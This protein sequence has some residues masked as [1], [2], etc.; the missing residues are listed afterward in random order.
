MAAWTAASIGITRIITAADLWPC[1][2]LDPDDSSS[3]TAA[4]D[5]NDNTEDSYTMATLLTGFI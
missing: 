1:D 4:N 3:S 5:T 2:D